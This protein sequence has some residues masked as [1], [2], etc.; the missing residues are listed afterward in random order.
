MK[1]LLLFSALFIFLSCNS[2]DDSYYGY[3]PEYD[4]KFVDSEEKLQ[5]WY[6]LVKESYHKGDSIHPGYFYGGYHIGKPYHNDFGKISS[7]EFQII[8]FP[9]DKVTMKQLRYTSI[10]DHHSK[11][12]SGMRVILLNT[13]NDTIMLHVQDRSVKMI[14]EAKD[15]NGKWQPIEY[16][17][18]SFCGN[19][20]GEAYL[21]PNTFFETKAYRYKG[22]F[23]TMLRFKLLSKIKYVDGIYK[24]EFTYSDPFEGSVNYSQ[25]HRMKTHTFMDYLE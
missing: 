25:F 16:W 6:V 11:F 22:S 5:A 14:Q 23:K 10:V 24:K 17:H 15:P 20:Y 21:P 2:S 13:S 7:T 19:S 12:T 3:E 1:N 9:E 18:H 8:V 4:G